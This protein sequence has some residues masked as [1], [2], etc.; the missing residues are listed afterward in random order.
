[1]KKNLLTLALTFLVSSVAQAQF[2]NGNQLYSWLIS[3][4]SNESTMGYT[5]IAGVSDT[6]TGVNHCFGKGVTVRQIGDTVL[7]AMKEHP[8]VRNQPADAIVQV[9][10]KINWPCKASPGSDRQL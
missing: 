7:A 5:Y 10:L 8:T 2:F 6:G 9:V 4:D 3:A 1:M